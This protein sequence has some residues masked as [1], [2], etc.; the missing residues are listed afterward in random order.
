LVALP[1]KEEGRA[2]ATY[3]LQRRRYR[4]AVATT[5]AEAAELVALESLKVAAVGLELTDPLGLEIIARLRAADAR[6]PVVAVHTHTERGEDETT[7]LQEL[8]AEP[9]YAPFL[10]PEFRD[11]LNRAAA[12][13][14]QLSGDRPS[15]RRRHARG[16]V[17]LPGVV[18]GSD[19]AEHCEVVDV[20][21]GGLRL[22][23]EKRIAD[24]VQVTVRFHSP[25]EGRPFELVG[26]VLRTLP[27]G[28]LVILLLPGPVTE[29][30]QYLSFVAQCVFNNR[31][32]VLVTED[33]EAIQD[34]AAR[35][36]SGTGYRVVQARGVAEADEALQHE[37][38]DLLLANIDLPDGN[39]IEFV[40]SAREAHPALCIEFSSGTVS[41]HDEAAIEGMGLSLLRKPWTAAALRGRVDGLL[42][43]RRDEAAR[44]AK[45]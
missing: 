10:M 43:T 13:M 37:P 24:G 30:A 15:E 22:R 27:N 11:S 36:L 45:G 25:L 29:R 12:R 3:L 18:E 31:H 2:V 32:R 5:G 4:S 35:A 14:T 1:R 26:Q 17:E 9:L 39:G 16:A 19:G 33:N 28:E 38:V 41:G 40:R 23:A 21:L 34:L 44:G 6:L 8:N 7:K 20:S 42:R